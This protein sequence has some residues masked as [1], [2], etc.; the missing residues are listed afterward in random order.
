MVRS[1]ISSARTRHLSLLSPPSTNLQTNASTYVD[2]IRAMK[3][4]STCSPFLHISLKVTFRRN[5]THVV[6]HTRPTHPVFAANRSQIVADRRMLVIFEPTLEGGGRFVDKPRTP[7]RPKRILTGFPLSK[8]SDTTASPHPLQAVALNPEFGR[9]DPGTGSQPGPRLASA[10]HLP[11]GFCESP[12][13]RNRCRGWLRPGARDPL[14]AD[15]R[16]TKAERA[17]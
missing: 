16:A 9:K 2:N 11:S 3:L 4:V 10:R 6:A 1:G 13:R 5:S 17:R 7:G 15:A 14:G 12:P 8:F